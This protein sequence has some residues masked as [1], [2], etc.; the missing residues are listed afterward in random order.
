MDAII[1]IGALIG[2]LAFGWRRG[3]RSGLKSANPI[4]QEALTTQA[5]DRA[6]YLGTLRRELANILVWRDPQRYL[7]FYR[8]LHAEITSLVSWR[9]EEVDKRLTELRSRYQFYSDFDAMST[10]DHVLY[11]EGYP[12]MSYDDLEA[13]YKDIVMFAALSSISDPSWKAAASRHFVHTTSDTDLAHLSEY[14]QKIEDT[15]FRLRLERIT[16][17]G[18]SLPSIADNP[19]DF[20]N[21]AYSIKYLPHFA[22][23]RY[24]IHLKH[25]NEFGIYSFYISDDGQVRRSYYRSDH[26]F[27]LEQSLCYLSEVVEEIHFARSLLPVTGR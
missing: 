2:G 7:Q 9:H 25:T 8:K 26:T 1:G 13:R 6:N 16:E 24:G 12:F 10:R 5:I 27:E 19:L 23:N 21:D 15:K 20:D 18:A 4:W 14:V 11:A 22:E 3:W 17:S